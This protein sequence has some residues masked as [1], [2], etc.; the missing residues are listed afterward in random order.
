[1]DAKMMPGKLRYTFAGIALSALAWLGLVILIG[2]GFVMI[3]FAAPFAGIYAFAVIGYAGVISEAHEFARRR[4]R[5]VPSEVPGRTH[6]LE[7]TLRR[8]AQ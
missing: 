6:R 4:A 2:M 7:L 1:M 5:W 3:G 8:S